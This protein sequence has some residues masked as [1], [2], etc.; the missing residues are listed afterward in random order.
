M[1]ADKS[2]KKEIDS[3]DKKEIDKVI[4][5][6]VSIHKIKHPS[7]DKNKLTAVYNLTS[8]VNSK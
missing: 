6:I 3:V 1:L 5:F 4:D 7:K 2:S 8:P